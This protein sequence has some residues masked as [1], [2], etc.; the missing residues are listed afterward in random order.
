MA[1]WLKRSARLAT[2]FEQIS[3]SDLEVDEFLKKHIEGIRAR[4]A[5]LQQDIAQ[6]S[7]RQQMPLRRF[8]PTQIDQFIDALR[9]EFDTE[10]SPL[11][12]IKTCGHGLRG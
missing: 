11:A 6:L 2:L 8:G 12:R 9:H 1:Q 10:K 3:D 5:A 7:A 4:I